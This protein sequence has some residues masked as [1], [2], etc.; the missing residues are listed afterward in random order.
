[1]RISWPSRAAP[2]RRYA[3]RRDAAS[4]PDRRPACSRAC[5]AG[6]KDAG[7]AP[8]RGGGAAGFA[9][10]EAC[11]TRCAC[12]PRCDSAW[13]RPCSGRTSRSPARPRSAASSRPRR[14][15]CSGSARDRGRGRI[16]DRDRDRART[17]GGEGLEASAGPPLRCSR[18]ANASGWIGAA[19]PAR[20]PLAVGGSTRRRGPGDRRGRGH[21]E[22][23]CTT[24]TAGPLPTERG[25]PRVPLALPCRLGRSGYQPPPTCRARA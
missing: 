1:M 4:S 12:P 3:G 2:R 20:G 6:R 16:R 13:T 18:R 25:G 8:G 21:R 10:R 19:V 14:C 17:Q 5:A 22:L 24:T 7:S 23:P 15:C 11:S 9:L